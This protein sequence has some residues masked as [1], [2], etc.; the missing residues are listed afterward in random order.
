M[1]AYSLT[2]TSAMATIDITNTGLVK[3]DEV[4]QLYIMDA[5]ASVARPAK[6]LKRFQRIT[7]EAGEMI[8]V[9]FKLEKDAFAF[10]DPGTDSWIVEPGIFMIMVG[11]SSKDIRVSDSLELK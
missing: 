2:S 3:G 7:L 4:V 10:F 6:E 11:S 9:E 1:R 5:Y 8:Q